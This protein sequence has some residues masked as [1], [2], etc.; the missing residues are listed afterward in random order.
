[1]VTVAAAAPAYATSQAPAG[2]VTFT[3][4]YMS[5]SPSG[6]S[7]SLVGGVLVDNS[8]G[9]QAVDLLSATIYT[10][11][12]APATNVGQRQTV[13]TVPLTGIQI[14]A[15][16][17]SGVG[18]NFFYKKSTTKLNPPLNGKRDI[19]VSYYDGT[20]DGTVACTDFVDPGDPAYPH[21]AQQ[22]VTDQTSISFAYSTGGLTYVGVAPATQV[23][24]KVDGDCTSGAGA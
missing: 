18:P 13:A 20:S 2:P 16:S 15:G 5:W 6:K 1:V 3:W 17:W 9:S 24:A 19:T 4:Y 23:S 21:F 11:Y 14:P 10:T 12:H 7:S 8:A 22:L